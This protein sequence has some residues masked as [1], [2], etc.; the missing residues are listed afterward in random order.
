MSQK[1]TTTSPVARRLKQARQQQGLSQKSLGIKAGIDE[2]SS[3]AR[4][5][6]YEREK[7]VPD[8]QTAQRLANALKVP[9][10]YLY[11][12]D[13]ALATLVLLFSQ[14]SQDKKRKILQLLK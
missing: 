2:F 11:T 10:T 8:Y 6:Q 4:I 13:E 7:H 12:D 3:S 1:K 5:N 9:V 14:A